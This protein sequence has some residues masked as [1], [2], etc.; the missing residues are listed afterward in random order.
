MKP[1][2]PTRNPYGKII[3]IVGI[4]LLLAFIIFVYRTTNN[5]QNIQGFFQ[6]TFESSRAFFYSFNKKE[7][8][9]DLLDLMKKNE[10]LNH[11]MVNFELMKRENEALKSQFQA[12]PEISQSLVAA[13]IIGFLGDNKH[14]ESFVVSAGVDQGIKKGM[15]VITSKNLVGVVEKVSK[16]YVTVATVTNPKFQVLAKLPETNASG[17]VIGNNDF[18]VMDKV[19]ITDS[20]KKEAIVVTKGEVDSDGVGVLPDLVIGRIVSV[21]KNES[22]PFQSAEVAPLI[23]LSKL[24]EVFIVVLI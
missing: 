18:A 5:A 1:A 9:S 6:N 22:E 12:A 21:S 8:Q 14:P 20:L 11:R 23:D 3:P 16:N 2:F 15:M 24:T 19:V 7:Q 13:K 17:I 4:F 10:E